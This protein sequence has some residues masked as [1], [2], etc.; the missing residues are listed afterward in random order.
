TKGDQ[1]ALAALK[2]EDRALL[3]KLAESGDSGAVKAL[4]SFDRNQLAA[5]VARGERP[6]A[7]LAAFDR[8]VLEAAAARGD[9]KA[10]EAL[11]AI[12]KSEATAAVVPRRGLLT[13]DVMRQTGLLPEVAMRHIERLETPDP[14]PPE[15]PLEP[16][17]KLLEL[18]TVRRGE[19]PW[20]TAERILATDGKKHSVDEVRAL[21]KAIQA[22]YKL[23]NNG[24]GDMSGLKVK[25]SFAGTSANTFSNIVANCKDDKVKALLL[26][27]AKS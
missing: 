15:K 18:A 27:L 5:A 25:Y 12:R 20:Q 7:E 24:N 2:A 11:A 6:A 17:S 16:S 22:A 26:S 8:K 10:I 4:E 1:A 23:D 13:T 21:T 9:A 19:G 14:K 3:A